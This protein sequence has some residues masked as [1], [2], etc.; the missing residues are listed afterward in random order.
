M[1]RRNFL[2]LM[3]WSV[4]G[5]LLVPSTR[6]YSFPKVIRRYTT[7]DMWWMTRACTGNGWFTTDN[8]LSIE[9]ACEM[10]E[11][12]LRT[13]D[14]KIERILKVGDRIIDHQRDCPITFLNLSQDWITR[15]TSDARTEDILASG[16]VGWWLPAEE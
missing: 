15:A 2:E 10:T 11:T 6:V 16:R 3:G 9:G 13:P 7:P 8:A 14:G 4:A 1:K 12:L 5:S